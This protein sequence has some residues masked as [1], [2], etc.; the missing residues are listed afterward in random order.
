MKTF[1]A[2]HYSAF[3]I[4]QGK[5]N[6]RKEHLTAAVLGLI[7]NTVDYVRI[8]I[9]NNELTG[10]CLDAGFRPIFRITSQLDEILQV[11]EDQRT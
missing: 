3:I 5:P 8:I 2:Y 7:F 1:M 4:E 9:D 10:Y 6:P 11:A